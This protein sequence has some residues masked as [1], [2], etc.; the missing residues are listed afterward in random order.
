M[1]NRV[2][3]KDFRN[4]RAEAAVSTQPDMKVL[5]P[6]HP[7][8]SV[9]FLP[10]LKKC[11][12][13]LLFSAVSAGLYAQIL[14]RRPGTPRDSVRKVSE[15]TGSDSLTV[16]KDTL[17]PQ[18][19]IKTAI[20]YNA[21]DSIVYD[22]ANKLVYLYG[23][24]K[25]TYGEINLE[26]EQIQINQKTNVMSA[27]GVP[28]STGKLLGI[29][30]FK[31]GAE[32]FEAKRISYSPKTQKGIIYEVVTQQGEGYIH[33]E[34]VKKNT[35]GDLF[36]GHARYTTCN[37]AHPHFYINAN[38]IKMV[39]NKQIVTGPFN[40]NISDIP[41]PVGFA[42]GLFPINTK[43][44]KSGIIF[45]TYGEES[46]QGGRGF[47][48]RNG[49]YYWAASEYANLVFMGEIYSKGGW[50]MNISSQYIKRYAFTGTTGIRYNRRKQG[51]EGQQTNIDDIWLNW[52]H[53]PQTRGTGR[54]SASV[55]AG[56][57][58]FNRRNNL[59]D[60]T[61]SVRLSTSFNSNISYSK[62]FPGTPFS[63]S[64]T[65]RHDMNVQTRI[66][67][68]TLP[69][70]SVNMN[71][72]YPLNFG[73][74]TSSGG[75]WWQTLNVGYT[76][77][78][79]QLLSNVNT[80]TGSFSFPVDY[81][82]FVVSGERQV[83]RD[84][85]SFL[86]DFP[87]I[88]KN[89]QL[90]VVHNLPFSLTLKLFRYFSLNPSFNY[91]ETWYPRRLDYRYNPET[92]KVRVDTIQKFSRFYSYNFSAG[93]TTRVFGT[94]TFREGS[95]I[96]AIRHTLIPSV[97][98]S[99]TP[100]FGAERFG[101]F[102]KLQLYGDPLTRL[103]TTGKAND[104]Q[105]TQLV[106]RY[107][108]FFLGQPSSG[109]NG[110]ISF[111][112]SNT[113]EAKIKPK[114]KAANPA[115]TTTKVAEGT[116]KSKFEKLSILDQ[117]GISAGYNLLADPLKNQF[118]LSPI[119]LNAA[120]RLLNNKLNIS[121]F[122]GLNPYKYVLDSVSFRDPN[123]V[124]QRQIPELVFQSRNLSNPY[125][126]RA[127]S[128]MTTGGI[129][130]LSNFNASLSTSLRP[131]GKTKKVKPIPGKVTEEQAREINNNPNDYIAWDI[132]WDLSLSYAFSYSKIGFQKVQT[133]QTFNFN[134]NL[135]ITQ[136][137]KVNFSSG[138]DFVRKQIAYT[139]IGINR[140]LHCWVMSFNWIPFGQYQSYSFNIRANASLLQD[141]KLTRQR[142]WYDRVVQ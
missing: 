132:P 60:P 47:Y 27:N 7:C 23:N 34:M 129:G 77:R 44:R 4:A 39:R 131:K 127:E 137:W 11:L 93:V 98:F 73:S 3:K 33:G 138:F 41:L 9:N 61:G 76:L 101:F 126:S 66:M 2:W 62:T 130:Q 55:N 120:T 110:S 68:L 105:F 139:N 96:Q 64:A 97:S 42:F 24:A 21:K 17:K 38:K 30:K 115:D 118:P 26:A 75:K 109:A 91:T 80:S 119:S 102:Q 29:P 99:Y 106:S 63:L 49:G 1:R 86:N 20:R 121:I 85:L 88:L 116:K 89:A 40:F 31:N 117:F 56:S 48:L 140:D 69:D 71:R 70:I 122:G 18:G 90:G 25:V 8:K 52:S 87:T 50:G 136:K 72:I 94:F 6:L 78:G 58:G 65:V 114:K 79:S 59:S 133:T 13:L 28:D 92:G 111:S 19:D 112:L 108:G 141:L 142:T 54:F 22:I 12:L 67:N 134:G 35:E 95:R 135:S 46:S 43:S 36:I 82:S 125:T 5:V 123:V 14:P 51:D 74:I 113:L 57:N 84:T 10:I 124:Y 32:N 37:L 103:I 53:T 15:N 45:P 100:D 128:A 107:N 104:P 83:R 81:N 16:K